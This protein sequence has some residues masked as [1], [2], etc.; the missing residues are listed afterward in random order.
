MT[1][2]FLIEGPS[3][4]SFSGGRT[5]GYMLWRSLQARGGRLPPD[6]YVLFANTGKEREETLEFVHQ[7]ETRWAVPVVWLEYAWDRHAAIGWAVVG[8]FVSLFCADAPADLRKK[9]KPTFRVVDFATANRDGQPFREVI[10]NREFLPNPVTRFCTAELKIRTMARWMVAQGHSAWT[11]VVGFR[12]D[13]P[14]RVRRALAGEG[15]DPW[16]YAFPLF[17][18]GI[19]KTDIEAFWAAQPFNLRLRS[20]EGNCDLCFLKGQ[21]KRERIMRDRPDLANWWIEAEAEARSSSPS[22]A[23]FRYKERPYTALLQLSKRPMLP[24]TEA[25]LDGPDDLGDC[26][27]SAD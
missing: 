5:S 19:T 26:V 16:D 24:F 12:G 7:V 27:C 2:P 13:E 15:R 10:W 11:D 20:W 23:R 4:L 14:G 21:K 9:Y 3:H 18:A 8:F 22:G 1:D 17:A 6:V 25:E